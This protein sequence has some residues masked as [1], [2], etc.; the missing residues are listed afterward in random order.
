MQII[1]QDLLTLQSELKTLFVIAHQ[2]NVTSRG[3]RGLAS[4]IFEEYPQTNTYKWLNLNIADRLVGKAQARN[5]GKSDLFT[6]PANN[7]QPY[8]FVANVNA[9]LRA[10]KAGSLPSSKDTRDHRILYLKRALKDLRDKLTN[11]NSSHQWP[12][13]MPY[14]FGCGLAGGDWVVYEQVLLDFEAKYSNV[15]VMLCRL[16]GSK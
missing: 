10:G 14:L 3:A 6:I 16:K 2:T 8:Y 9:Q 11:L 13:Y 5:L 7:G 15:D 4:S 1:N 12:I